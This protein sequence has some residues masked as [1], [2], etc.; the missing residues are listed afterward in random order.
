MSLVIL[1]SYNRWQA[2][3]AWG[4]NLAAVFLKTGIRALFGVAYSDSLW[5]PPPPP[6]VG[7]GQALEDCFQMLLVP[8]AQGGQGGWEGPTLSL[9]CLGRGG[10]G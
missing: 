4:H 9:L 1:G 8:G 7:R 6:D 10:G 5:G 2:S 3:A